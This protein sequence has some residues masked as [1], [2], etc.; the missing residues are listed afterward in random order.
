MLPGAP[1][2]RRRARTARRIRSLDAR[3]P[4]RRR[5]GRGRRARS[6]PRRGAAARRRRLRGHPPLRRPAVRARRAPRAHGA[7]RR[8]P[9]PAVRRR[10]RARRR[11]RAA[12]AR[13]ARSTRALRLV[14][15]RGGRRIGILHPPTVLPET[16]SLA[17]IT[18]APTRVLDGVKSLSYGANM[19]ATRLAQRGRRRRGAAR[20]AARPRARGADDVVLLR[21]RRR[22]LHAAAV[23]PHPRLDQPPRAAGGHRRAGARD[24]ARRPRVDQRGVPRLVAARGAAGALDRRP[25]RCRR[26]PGPVSVAA[27]ERVR[28]H[29]EAALRP[30]A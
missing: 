27:A 22:A 12:R 5:H 14:V 7:Q 28:E 10:R 24:D 16:I 30:P 2:C 3:H 26:R 1:A 23:G 13:P 18:Y 4:R 20:H 11:A 21:P 29:I 6:R 19:L 17:T 8:E 9:A 25:R 15:T